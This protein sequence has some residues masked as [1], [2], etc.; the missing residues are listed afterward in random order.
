[1]I[2]LKR[3]LSAFFNQNPA[4]IGN[5]VKNLDF[6]QTASKISMSG[7]SLLFTGE[8]RRQGKTKTQKAGIRVRVF[9]NFY[10]L[11]F[12]NMYLLTYLRI[13]TPRQNEGYCYHDVVFLSST[14]DSYLSWL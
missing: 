1:M 2:F 7:F 3:Y 10:F 4:L 8:Q 9:A 13:I 6:T 12:I 11:L 14:D 5:K